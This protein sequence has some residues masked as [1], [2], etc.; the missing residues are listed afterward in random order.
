MKKILTVA[1]LTALMLTIAVSA[2]A[3]T[4][5]GS[6]TNLTVKPAADGAN[7]SVSG[8]VTMCAI[9]LDAEGKIVSVHFD[10]VQPKAAFD[11]AGA[12][13]G[14]SYM[15]PRTK[16][17][18]KEEYGMKKVSAIGKEVYEQIA[19]LEAWCVGKTVEEVVTT[20]TYD[21]GDG[22]HTNVPTDPDLASGC[23][24]T[25]GDYLKALAKAAADAK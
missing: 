4:G 9:E 21:K 2:L 1:L 22:N 11:A 23:T 17:E 3:A 25:I 24:I 13:V 20:P 6:V 14:E 7:G 15:E 18:L 19:H 8:N 5:M 16:N 10:V 12:V